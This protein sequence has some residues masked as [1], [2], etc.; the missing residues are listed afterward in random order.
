MKIY[1]FVLLFLIKT[2]L[3]CA[4]DE[5]VRWLPWE[6]TTEGNALNLPSHSSNI[7]S[8]SYD[9]ENPN[10][11]QQ[12]V[13]KIVYAGTEKLNLRLK[14][15]SNLPKLS[16]QYGV[17]GE[18]RYEK[19]SNGSYLEM[20]NYFSPEA[21]GLPE[22]AYFS[23]TL[24][25]TGPMGRLEGTSEWRNFALPFN[26]TGAKSKASR[27]EMN[28]HF[29]G[30]GT[31]YMRNLR[32]IQYS[33][34]ELNSLSSSSSSEIWWKEEKGGAVGG[35]LGAFLGIYGSFLQWRINRS[36]NGKQIKPYFYF[37]ISLSVL[38]LILG[39]VALTVGQPYGVWFVLLLTGLIGS[40]IFIFRFWKYRMISNE[41]E[42]RRI[43]SFDN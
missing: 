1:L 10:D 16:P 39:V 41:I 27:L 29:T 3:S 35:V 19:I 30:P 9:F 34:T 21:P 20:W 42:L 4:N 33:T 14:T 26:S 2:S 25:G 22:G 15:I 18:I 17:I 11:K 40:S 37:I 23:R 6:L 8:A 5:V 38:L 32:L 12:T 13:L 24:G 43:A 7:L 36:Q 31:V 28:I